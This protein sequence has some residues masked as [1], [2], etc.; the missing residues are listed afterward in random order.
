MRWVISLLIGVI[1]FYFFSAPISEAHYSFTSILPAALLSL[2]GFI[3]TA[4]AIVVS[5][6]DQGLLKIV[7][8]KSPEA[9]NDI[10]SQFYRAARYSITYCLFLF[11]LDLIPLPDADKLLSRFAYSLSMSLFSLVIIQLL[12][13]ITTLE[14]ASY[15]SSKSIPS[16]SQGTS[17]KEARETYKLP[18]NAPKRVYEEPPE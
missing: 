15:I 6:K 17:P 16:E 10:M 12:M 1:V 3:L 2:A 7:A 13:A 5:L 14:D 8:D 4:A 11:F 9:W 18:N